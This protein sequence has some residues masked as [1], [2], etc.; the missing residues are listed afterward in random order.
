METDRSLKQSSIKVIV[1]YA[2]LLLNAGQNVAQQKYDSFEGERVVNYFVPKNW[3][4]LDTIAANPAPDVTNNSQRCAQYKRS[5][6]RYDYIKIYPPVKMADADRYATYDQEAPRM[7]MKVFTNAPVGTLVEIQLGKKTG[8]AY[9]EGTHSQFQAFT[10]KSGAWEELEFKY[11]QTPKGSETRARDVDQIT[12]LFTPGTNATH[13]F[14]FDDLTGPSLLSE[15]NAKAGRK[16]IKDLL[17]S[18]KDR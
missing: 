8:N 12:L 1:I 6:Q 9:P 3:G 10:T 11:S 16:K 18:E 15:H 13:V 7:K 14:Y 17:A 5:R 2:A 4:K